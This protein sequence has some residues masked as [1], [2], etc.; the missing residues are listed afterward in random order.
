MR[1]I[2]VERARHAGRL[3]HGGGRQRVELAEHAAPAGEDSV[4]VVALD[5]ALARLEE[6][7]PRKAQVVMLRYFAGLTVEET[8]AALDLSPS[9]IKK[10]WTVAR[11]WLFG[12][13]SRARTGGGGAPG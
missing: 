10:E 1:R 2:M 13:L 4:D 9:M 8:A 5:E 7:D 11:A 6:R 3:R 12:E